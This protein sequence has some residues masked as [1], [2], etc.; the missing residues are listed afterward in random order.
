MVLHGQFLSPGKRVRRAQASYSR[1]LCLADG[2]PSRVSAAQL[3]RVPVPWGQLSL[4]TARNGM[5]RNPNRLLN[6]SRMKRFQSLKADTYSF[7]FN[8]NRVHG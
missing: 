5:G 4:P 1:G 2:R 6:L 7:Q 8:P 3:S